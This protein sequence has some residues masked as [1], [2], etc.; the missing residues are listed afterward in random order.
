MMTYTNETRERY[1]CMTQYNIFMEI[2]YFNNTHCIID[3]ILY[4]YIIYLTDDVAQ[5]AI[6]I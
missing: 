4:T 3:N 1:F 2:P 5:E 6:F